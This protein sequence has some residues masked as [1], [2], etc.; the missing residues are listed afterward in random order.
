LDEFERAFPGLY[1]RAYGVAYVVLGDRMEAEDVAAEVCARALAHWS[2]VASYTEPWSIRV[3]G[4]LAI[5]HIRKRR[6]QLRNTSYEDPSLAE[7]LDLQR[8]LTSLP[9]RQREVVVLRFVADLPIAEVAAT[10]GCSTGTVKSH[11]NRALKSMRIAL[12]EYQ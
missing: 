11:C 10:L 2:K 7:R 12:A 1:R 3:A 6:P 4:N 9:R 8:A 5:D